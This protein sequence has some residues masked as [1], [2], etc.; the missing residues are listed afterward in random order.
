MG[1]NSVVSGLRCL[2]YLF[3]DYFMPSILPRSYWIDSPLKRAFD[4]CL[5]LVVSPFLVALIVLLSVFILIADRSWPLFSQQR[6]GRNGTPFRF[7]KLNTMGRHRSDEPSGGSGDARAT[8]LGKML[9]WMILDEVPQVLINVLN[10]DM[11]LVGPRPLL[12]ADIDLMRR[13]LGSEGFATWFVA[14]CS[15]RPGWTGRFGVSS[16][17]FKIHSGRYLYAR[18]K[19]DI[20]YIQTASWQMD[21]KTICIHALLPFIDK[22]Y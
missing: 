5:V 14:Y 21:I 8:K 18:K 22:N 19:F 6:I 15:V 17:R 12:Q 7:Y 4:V 20:E 1:N 16:R 2:T 11:S 3:A 9:R 10:G 13:H